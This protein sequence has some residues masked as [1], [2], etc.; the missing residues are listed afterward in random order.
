MSCDSFYILTK[1]CRRM[2]TGRCFAWRADI[3]ALASVHD[4]CARPNDL[5]IDDL[6]AVL[7][8]LISQSDRAGQNT[9]HQIPIAVR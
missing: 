8:L 5:G 9:P 2:P 7:Q 4:T 3:D 6:N 1:L